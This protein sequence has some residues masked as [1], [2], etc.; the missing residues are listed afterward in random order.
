MIDYRQKYKLSSTDI[1]LIIVE[2][3]IKIIMRKTF[4]IVW[5]TFDILLLANFLE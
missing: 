4:L 5:M 2:A 3:E 1:A